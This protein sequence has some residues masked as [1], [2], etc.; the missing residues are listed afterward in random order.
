MDA[1]LPTLSGIVIIDSGSGRVAIT[2]ERYGS[3]KNNRAG[4]NERAVD[5]Q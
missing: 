3:A 1:D 2:I 5:Q 4:G